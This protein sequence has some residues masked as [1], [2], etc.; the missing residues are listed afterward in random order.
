M[1]QTVVDGDTRFLNVPPG[2]VHERLVDD[3]F[4]RSAIERT[5]GPAAWGLSP[6]LTRTEEIAL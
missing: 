5:G 6:D 3:R 1:R 2:D 4:V